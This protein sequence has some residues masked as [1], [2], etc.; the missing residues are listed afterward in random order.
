MGR[1]DAKPSNGHPIHQFVFIMEASL[2]S[3]SCL[4]LASP[5]PFLP[6]PSLCSFPP[7]VSLSDWVNIGADYL[8]CHWSEYVVDLCDC[9]VGGYVCV[10]VCA[11]VC[12]CVC[13]CVLCVWLRVC[14]CGR[15][16]VFVYV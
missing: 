2:L 6:S 5:F 14:V 13:V 7:Q 12:V 3:L 11:C 15:V 10:C 9:G 8:C 16:C 1:E 4:P